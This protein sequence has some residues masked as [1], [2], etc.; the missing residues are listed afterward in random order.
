MNLKKSNTTKFAGAGILTAVAASLCCI[1]P[2]LAL[3]S[4][5][6]GAASAFSWIEP[7]RPWLIGITILVLGFAWFQ[8]LKP[9]KADEITCDCEDETKLSFWQSKSFLTIVTIFAVLMMAFPYYESVFYTKNNKEVIVVQQSDIQTLH[10]DV[11]GMTCTACNNHVENAAY[12]VKGVLE[13]KADYHKGKAEVKFDKSKT[14]TKKIMNSID[15]TS[16]KVTG[17]SL[18]H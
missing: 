11:E 3:I 4:G 18:E 17:D 13:A 6:A 1:T 7:Y 5:A 12:Q 15:A 10:L 8:K 14:S 16:Y 2:V 9:S